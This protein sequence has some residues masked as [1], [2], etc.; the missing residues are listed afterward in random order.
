MN[1]PEEKNYFGHESTVTLIKKFFIYKMMASNVF[2]NYSLGGIKLLYNI[3]GKRFANWL[4]ETSAGS[5]FTGGVTL[6]DLN[7][8]IDALEQTKVGGIGM[9][10]AEGLENLSEEEANNFSEF[11]IDSIR[12]LTEGRQEGHYA[13][14]LTALVSTE[15]MRKMSEAQELY[16]RLVLNV[17]Y[18][19]N[20]TFT[21]SEEQLRINLKGIGVHDI[22]EN[23]TDLQ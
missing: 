9:Y 10:V 22:D 11:S 14:K 17:S 13:L 19:P 6:K 7:Q 18:D 16:M 4:I 23:A 8:G 1:P 5:I 2:I 20:D 21:L 12:E 15:L 3:T